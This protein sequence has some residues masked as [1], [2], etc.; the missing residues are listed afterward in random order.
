VRLTNIYGVQGF[1]RIV[2]VRVYPVPAVN[3]VTINASDGKPNGTAICNVS[4]GMGS[5]SY[6]W[7]NGNTFSIVNNLA[8]GDYTVTV[9]DG[10]CP[11]IRS[12]TIGNDPVFPRDIVD[13]EYFF[14]ADPGVGNG[15]PLNIAGGDSVY[16]ATL[17]PVSGLSAGY[18]LLFIRVADTYGRWSIC[19]QERFYVYSV[20][21]GSL[22]NRPPIV[23]GEYFY[24]QDPGKGNGIQISVI[25]G[26]EVSADLATVTTG[27]QPGFHFLSAR[28]MDSLGIWS[29]TQAQKIYVNEI[30]AILQ[31]NNQPKIVAAEYFFDADPGPGNGTF[32]PFSPTGDT[33]SVNRFFPV[34]N[35]NAGNHLVYVRIKDE[36]GKW[37]LYGRMEFNIFPTN[38]TTPT[39]DFSSEPAMA[40]VPV[41]F[42]NTTGN[43]ADSATYQWDFGNDGSVEY[44]TKDIEHTFAVSGNYDVKLTV[45]NSDTCQASILKQVFVGPLPPTA[46]IVNG[47]PDFCDGDSVEMIAAPG[48]LYQWWPTGEA[49]RIIYAKNSGNYYCWLSTP[50]GLEV[51]SQV[52]SITRHQIPMV[53]LHTNDASGGNSNGSAWVEV[54]GGIGNYSYNWSSGDTAFYVNNLAPGSYTVQVDDGHCPEV[55]QFMIG[56]HPVVPGNI[57]AAEY[58]F[59][60][61]PGTGLGTA[62]N[63]SAADTAEYFTG[64]RVTGLSQGYHIVY[65][66]VMDTYNRWS[67]HRQQSFYV[68]PSQIAIPP[69]NQPPITSAEYFVDLNISNRP[70][71]GVGL[72]K[73]VDVMPGDSV[74]VLFGYPVDTLVVG[75][76]AIAARVKD[77]EGKWSIICPA[78]FYLYDTTQM[79]V[80]KIQPP[81]LA[82]EYFLD[83]DPGVGN[84]HSMSITPGDT[85]DWSGGIPMGATPLGIHNLYVR[86]RDSGQQWSLYRKATFEVVD[87]TQPEANFTFEQ[88]CI[89]VPVTFNDISENVNPSAT[90][91]WDIN[92]DGVVDY[93]TPGNITHQYTVPGIYQCKLK[94]TH[95]V[96]CVDSIIKTVMFP[97][98]ILPPDTTIYTDQSLVLNAGP[99]YAYLW[100]TGDTAQTITVNGS[101]A[102][103]GLHN[104][105]V[106][107]T[108]GQSCADSDAINVIVMLPPRDLVVESASIIPGTIPANG[109]SAD[110]HCVIRNTGTISAVASV[111]KYY[112]SAD[113]SLSPDDLLLG[114]GIVNALQPG[115]TEAVFSRE[116]IPP[117]VEGQSG[118][119]LFK[120]DGSEIVV[121]SDEGNNVKPVQFNYGPVFIP[122]NLSVANQTIANG[123]VN[124]FNAL[125]TLTVA[126]NG[127]LFQVQPGGSATLIAGMKIRFLPGTKVFSGGYLHGY[128][129]TT[130]DYCYPALSANSLANSGPANEKV[131]PAGWSHGVTE[132]GSK[133]CYV[134]PNPTKG[135]FN[136]VLSSANREWPVTVKIYNA[137]GA[138]IKEAILNEGKPHRLSLIGQKPGLYIIYVGHGS[139]TEVEKVILY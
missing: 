134:Y 48:Y 80:S 110:L 101:T 53:A 77:G 1:S 103:I 8:P 54:T 10:R 107:V 24:D 137:Y 124:C 29:L 117:G 37:G 47:N 25:S 139:N 78:T 49:S 69:K 32:I 92:N 87:C 119:V 45:I 34:G 85:V 136:L 21:L 123:Q 131:T 127:T 96:A 93:T 51:K 95:N 115:T 22:A 61:D 126:G 62:M 23:K 72:G 100:N 43:L 27:I 63:I 98:V 129:A 138:F 39:P 133:F 74:D 90:Y 33:I 94:I 105:S 36:A 55:K 66:R 112:L 86:V 9:S 4:G 130:G 102:G 46:I 31:P 15:S 121:E 70:D 18:H 71:P 3:I 91:E 113:N 97:Y 111:V 14:D 42:T 84:G 2:H 116:L 67:L 64:C 132:P 5:Y 120:A 68:Y 58:F 135:E 44:D 82:A 104:F 41:I 6:L 28:V 75:F 19:R 81:I 40:G 89:N 79:D 60:T 26:D 122:V 52:I 83:V 57:L 17:M 108:N 125:E 35:L 7:S 88:T 99:G 38:C 59:D 30:P 12:F 118:Y 109:D 16:F 20:N 56:T 106:V 13:A 65:I 11:V 76:H 50:T 73:P 128:I 114:F